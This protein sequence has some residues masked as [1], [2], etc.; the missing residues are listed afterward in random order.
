MSFF[1]PVHP[2][3]NLLAHPLLC[4][5]FGLFGIRSLRPLRHLEIRFLNL[6]CLSAL[7]VL[8]I[9]PDNGFASV[10]ESCH[11]THNRTEDLCPLV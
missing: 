4:G 1:Q 10:G 5:F 2:F 7:R 11:T 3:F 6:R 9:Q 8:V